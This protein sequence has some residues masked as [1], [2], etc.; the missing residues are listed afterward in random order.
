MWH[1]TIPPILLNMTLTGSF[2][3]LFVLLARL[4]LKKAPKIYS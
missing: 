1:D 4:A 3:I 2:I